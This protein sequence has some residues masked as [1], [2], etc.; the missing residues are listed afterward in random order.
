MDGTP[1]GL[2]VVTINVPAG[3]Q[4]TKF[5]NE[6]YPQLSNFRGLAKL[7]ASSNVVLTAVRGRYN[8]RGDFLFTSIPV[9]NDAA[10]V[11]GNLIVPHVTS[12]LGY[13]TEIIMFGQAGP[14]KL[15]LFSQDGVLRSS[16]VPK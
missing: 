8:E 1:V 15:Y 12:G 10:G 11:T 16:L 5:I 13:S 6:L 9:L 4:V 7:T 14:G 2:P 3:G